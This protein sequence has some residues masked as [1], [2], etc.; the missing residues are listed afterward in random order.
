MK[1]KHVTLLAMAVVGVLAMAQ[2]TSDPVQAKLDEVRALDNLGGREDTSNAV[3]IL[4]GLKD[5]KMTEDQHDTWLRY[6]RDFA[7][8]AGDLPWLR[9]LSGVE[10]PFSNDMVY[11]VLFG[12]GKLSKGDLDGA[13]KVLKGVD[14]LRINPRDQRRVYG[15]MAR[16]ARLKGNTKLELSY[17]EK[18]IEHLPSWPSPTCMACHDSPKEKDKVTAL[19]ISQLWFGERYSEIL[20]QTHRAK[21]VRDE[22]LRALKADPHDDLARIKLGYAQVA[23][24]DKA[25]ASEAFA[26]LPYAK[27]EG[28]ALPAARMFF[29]FP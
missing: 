2:T 1:G 11:T 5:V 3:T 12:Y 4:K 22:S 17:I 15:M 23:L 7:I 16:I 14:L 28:R 27:V 21:A 9:S 6:S 13:E 26:A 29:A 10:S 20:A 25:A 18:I 24:G 19:P 8:R